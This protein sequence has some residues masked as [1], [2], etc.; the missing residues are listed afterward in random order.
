M[1]GANDLIMR[2]IALHARERSLDE[3]TTYVTA[4]G[5]ALCLA[6][7][8]PEYARALYLSMKEQEG[9]IMHHATS[10]AADI[11]VRCVPVTEMEAQ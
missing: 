10:H 6:F 2:L 8:H 5:V 11:T 1:E 9:G 7:E 4:V 3:A